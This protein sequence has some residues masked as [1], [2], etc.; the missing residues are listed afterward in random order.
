MLLEPA[1]LSRL[2]RM[3]IASGRR[4]HGNFPGEHRSRR[5][6]T[7]TDFA[8]WRPYVPGD[9]FRRIDY[10][11]Y[12]R[13][14][15]LVIRLF[16]SEDELMLRIVLDA[17]GSM[18]FDNK[19]ERAKEIAGALTYVAACRRNR[20]RV[21][22]AGDGVK[23]GPWVASPS[24]AL[25]LMGW[26][27]KVEPGGRADLGAALSIVAS[28]GGM[29]GLTVLISD[30]LDES[31]EPAVRRLGGPSHQGALLHILS[32]GDRQPEARGDL[33]LVDSET[34]LP[35]EVSVSERVLREY[36]ARTKSWMAGVRGAATRRGIRYVIV[37]PKEQLESL[38]LKRMPSEGLFR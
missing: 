17:S 4:I 18:S 38:L 20:V 10:Q 28:Q 15:R 29:R 37:D 26:L 35:M 27:E 23:P 6:G 32:E 19:I 16:E 31:W 33:M 9:D 11:I 36:R 12:A 21:F 7:S 3:A 25:N 14:D 34:D 24:A 30:L 13:L 22:V 2:E 8:D 1:I 5:L